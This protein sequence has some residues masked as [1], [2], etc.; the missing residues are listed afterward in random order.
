MTA[1]DT[2]AHL[3]HLENLDE[4]L[5]A[6]QQQGVEGIVAVSVDLESNK[7]N[8]AI[9]RSV[10]SPKIYL[11]LGIHPGN[12]KAEEVDECLE[13][14]RANV[15]EAT[16][17]GEIGLDFWYKWVRKDQ[18]KKDEQRD[19][20]RR[21]LAM[22]KEF[23]LPAIIHARG[24]W[25][26]CLETIQEVGI[27][28]AVFHWYSGPLDVL[29]D[30]INAG[31]FV[32]ASPSLA[33]SPQSREAIAHAPIEQTLIETDSPVFYRYRDQEGGFTAQPKD[34][35]KTLAAYAELKEVEPQHALEIFNRNAKQLFGIA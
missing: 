30:I 22:A 4:A 1:F 19:I 17:I 12:I 14:M 10:K 16:A 35:F 18:V 6:A 26:E 29:N 8:L 3:D 33:V 20:F 11:A 32:S 15:Q 24:T 5:K 21:Q 9:K 31:Y 34:V 23:A 27:K 7:K 13:F 2:H 28:R 25:R